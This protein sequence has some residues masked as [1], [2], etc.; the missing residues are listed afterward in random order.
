MKDEKWEQ[1][2][3][4]W[5]SPGFTQGPTYPVCGVSWNDAKVFC[6]WLTKKERHERI[7]GIEQ[8]YRLATDAEWSV[9]VGLNENT[10]GTPS[11]KHVGIK[12]IYPWGTQW[13][14]PNGVGNYGQIL[15][16]DDYPY[17]SPVGS[18]R[19]NP[20]GLYDM[21]G[22][23]W[24]WCEDWSDGTQQN[25]VLRGPS[26]YFSHPDF[27]LSSFRG[28]ATPDMRNISIGFR[29]VLVVGGKSQ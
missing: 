2:G 7:I 13:P 29:C 12:A 1:C 19:A 14:P 21:G 22:N 4:T 10:R 3:D 11:D 25:R 9:A 27:L 8:R 17:S 15:N 26:W 24:Q 23:V 28:G 18:F 20:F 16:V 6:A 5:K